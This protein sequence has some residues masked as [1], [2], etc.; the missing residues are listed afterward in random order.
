MTK[1]DVYRSVNPRAHVLQTNKGRVKDK[2]I[3][4]FIL[5]KD[6]SLLEWKVCE[7]SPKSEPD[8]NFGNTTRNHIRMFKTNSM[9]VNQSKR[10][11]SHIAS[12]KTKPEEVIKN[13]KFLN[14]DK[15]ANDNQE[16][17][18]R[19]IDS[20]DIL[21]QIKTQ[22][23]DFKD[24]SYFK[25]VVVFDESEEFCAGDYRIMEDREDMESVSSM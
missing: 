7:K 5:D 6:R 17:P 10:V 25:E 4:T 13:L 12:L 21:R 16:I 3:H 22:R 18:L 15:N 24:S 14:C 19:L 9:L 11:K 1:I 2:D 8:L 20:W 23:K